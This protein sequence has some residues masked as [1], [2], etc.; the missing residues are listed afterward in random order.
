MSDITNSRRAHWAG[1]CLQ[2][3][4][5]LTRSDLEDALCDLLADMMH[6][7]K[8]NNFDFC[9]ELERAAWH[10]EEELLEEGNDASADN[11]GGEQ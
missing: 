9:Q 6:W 5:D 7:A 4:M 1:L 10:F 3:F 2:Q 8:Q 11:A